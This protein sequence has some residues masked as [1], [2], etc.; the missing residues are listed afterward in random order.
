LATATSLPY[1]NGYAKDEYDRAVEYR[2]CPAPIEREDG[3]D[4]G[5]YLDEA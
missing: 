2:L 1:V 4:E 3:E 5:D